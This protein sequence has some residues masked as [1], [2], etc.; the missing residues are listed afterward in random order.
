MDDGKTV[1]CLAAVQSWHGPHDVVRTTCFFQ[2]T[3]ECGACPHSTFTMQFQVG[4]G[5][6]EVACP[7]WRSDGAR[8]RGESL[9]GYV[10]LRR[11]TCLIASPFPWCYSCRNHDPRELPRSEP[12][13][14]EQEPRPQRPGIFEED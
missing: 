11:E 10:M 4:I 1:R 8:M 9:L 13:W 3:A 7:R 12:G 14:W 5:N 2:L 6:Q